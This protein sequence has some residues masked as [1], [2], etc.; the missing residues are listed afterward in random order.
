MVTI[1]PTCF[2]NNSSFCIY[3]F[4][5]ILIINSDYFLK[6][7]QPVDLCNCEVLCFLWGT[8]WILK[9]YLDK[10]RLQ[11]DNCDIPLINF[12]IFK[13]RSL[14]FPYSGLELVCELPE[15]LLTKFP[16]TT[17]DCFGCCR[18]GCAVS[19]LTRGSHQQAIFSIS[20]WHL[21][22][23]TGKMYRYMDVCVSKFCDWCIAYIIWYF[24]CRQ[25]R[26]QI[27]SQKLTRGS[28]DTLRGPC[29][30]PLDAG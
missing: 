3:L 11:R 18:Q 19:L 29:S 27:I 20:S 17:T 9:Y 6:Q 21:E 23:G 24:L 28:R 25:Q 8:D 30:T 13:N 5:M 2:N 10:L 7:R 12:R 15:N 14:S 26:A 16:N 4:R 1:C 22:A